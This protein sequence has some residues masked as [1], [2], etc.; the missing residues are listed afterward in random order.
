[1]PRGAPL[2]G[3]NLTGRSR[4]RGRP[5]ERPAARSEGR[6]QEGAGADAVD[7]LRT[8]GRV[9]AR[10][11]DDERA[12]LGDRRT[13]E[14]GDAGG[15]LPAPGPDRCR[16]GLRAG[17]VDAVVRGRVREREVHRDG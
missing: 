13:R 16:A 4:L 10:Q 8:R 2:A 12:R 1:M 11:R 7:Q 5:V 6:M 15:R 14:H 3:R 17:V 9:Q